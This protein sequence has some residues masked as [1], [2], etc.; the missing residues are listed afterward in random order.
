[1]PDFARTVSLACHDLRTPLATVSGFAKTL[2]RTGE[3]DDRASRHVEMIDAASGQLAELLDE[4][5]VLARIEAG[6]YEPALVETDTLSLA[7]D[8]A[9]GDGRTV[10]TDEPAVRRALAALASAAARHGAVEVGWTVDGRELALSPVT[11]DA[12]PVVLGEEP[13]DFPAI[14]ARLVIETLG[15]SVAL[16]GETLRVRL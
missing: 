9:S 7:G 2:I 8:G 11:T 10:Q 6:R 12:A 5:G 14:V 15:G 1:V 16:E 3:L 13:K 4:L